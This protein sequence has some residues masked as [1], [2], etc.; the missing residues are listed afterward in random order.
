MNDVIVKNSDVH[1]KG[2]FAN[3][4]FKKGE[5]V[6]NWNKEN[7]YLSKKD[8]ENL[9]LSLKPFVAV[10]NNQYLLIAE[11]ERYMNHSCNPN[12]EISEDGSDFALRDI[13]RGEEITGSYTRVGALMGFECNCGSENCRKLI[14]PSKIEN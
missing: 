14:P 13:K 2:L 7:K 3:K 8:V 4:D 1:G 9:P 5:M 12:T 6:L 10:F 11:P